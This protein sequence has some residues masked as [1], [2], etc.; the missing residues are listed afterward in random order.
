MQKS[1][2][3]IGTIKGRAQK[4]ILSMKYGVESTTR[5]NLSLSENYYLSY[6]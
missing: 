4:V 3:V 2:K 1:K 5:N 6:F